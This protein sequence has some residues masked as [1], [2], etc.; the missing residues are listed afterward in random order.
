[1]NKE[2]VLQGLLDAQS[3]RVLMVSFSCQE[4]ARYWLRDTGCKYDMV[5]DTQKEIYG[6][7]G[8]GSSYL[9]ILKF[10]NLQKYAEYTVLKRTFPQVDPSFVDDIYQLGGDF[11]LNETGKVVYAHPCRSPVDR[12][13]LAEILSVVNQGGTSTTR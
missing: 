1:M 13:S 8:L 11:V 5:L 9:K 12:P 7:F 3:V 10:R 6:M 2:S 4:G